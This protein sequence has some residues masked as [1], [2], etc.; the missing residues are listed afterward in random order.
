MNHIPDEVLGAVDEFGGDLLLGGVE[1]ISEKLKSDLWVEII[2][3][4]E[5]TAVC[6]YK[7]VHTQSPPTIRDRGSF[8]TTIIDGVDTRL[9]QWG[10]EPPAAY[11]Y[12]G[13]VD[14]TH[15]YEGTLQLP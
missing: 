8:M 5:S 9:R 7:T 4:T 13:T 14:D 1:P 3:D 2:P 12:V 15:H 10:I 11:T 6:R